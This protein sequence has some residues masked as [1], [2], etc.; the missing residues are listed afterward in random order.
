MSEYLLN[1]VWFRLFDILFQILVNS[2]ASEESSVFS[3]D[4]LNLHLDKTILSLR[5]G[6]LIFLLFSKIKGFCEKTVYT[7]FIV[8]LKATCG[9]KKKNNKEIEFSTLATQYSNFPYLALKLFGT[10]IQI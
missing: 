4:T 8:Y 9:K 7:R 1:N 3:S 10:L 6:E 5:Q 2:L